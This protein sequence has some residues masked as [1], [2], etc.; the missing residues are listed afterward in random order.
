[1]LFVGDEQAIHI[2]TSYSYQKI[3]NVTDYA[4]ESD[5]NLSRFFIILAKQLNSCQMTNVF[6]EVIE[7]N[8]LL[9]MTKLISYSN[10]KL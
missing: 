1:M 2:I 6:H 10:T 7:L 3:V 5:N 9:K 4:C 8:V